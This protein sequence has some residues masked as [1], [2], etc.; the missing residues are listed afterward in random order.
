MNVMIDEYCT[1]YI[2]SD[3]LADF[4]GKERGSKMTKYDTYEL[5]EIYIKNNITKDAKMT[6]KLEATP[7]IRNLLKM[8]D[9][10]ILTYKNFNQWLRPHFT[11][12]VEPVIS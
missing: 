4:V 2:I 12:F 7:E 6:T 9:D 1:I 5:L 3:E 11:R 10:S 8:E